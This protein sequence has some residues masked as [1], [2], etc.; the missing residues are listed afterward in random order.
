MPTSSH[1]IT[2]LLARITANDE[3]A[4]AALMPI[5]YRELRRLARQYMRRERTDHT[6]EPTALVHEAYLRLVEIRDVNWE[7][8][9]H[10][11]GIAAQLMRQVLVDHARAHLAGKRG[12]NVAKVSLDEALVFSMEKSTELI[13][14]DEALAQ[15]AAKDPRLGKVVELHFFGGLG[16][17]EIAN[18]L[19]VSKKTVQRD[20]QLARAWLRAA[21]Q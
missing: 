13:A 4:R 11:F 20:W 3:E 6:L 15:L 18:L 17:S 8:R 1:E 14:L 5:V 19:G 12:G 21:I 16:F 2:K 7:G 10:F 9:T